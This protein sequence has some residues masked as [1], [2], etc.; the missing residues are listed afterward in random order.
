MGHKT[1]DITRLLLTAIAA[2]AFAIPC[3]AQSA[4]A[5]ARPEGGPQEEEQLDSLYFTAEGMGNLSVFFRAVK[6]AGL[7]DTLKGAGPFTVFAPTDDAFAKLPAETLEELFRPQNKERLRDILLTHIFAVRA[8]GGELGKLSEAVTL[9]RKPLPVDLAN[10]A[11][12]GGA[13]VTRTDIPATNGVMHLIDT[14]LM[15]A[16]DK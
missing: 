1:S 9:K 8:T 12:I 6:A 13:A 3:A 11:R 5:E 15:P 14:V 10:G 2:L 16:N 4:A 7:T